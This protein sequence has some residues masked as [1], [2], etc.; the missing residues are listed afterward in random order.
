MKLQK[1]LKDNSSETKPGKSFL[2]DNDGKFST[3]QIHNPTVITIDDDEESTETSHEIQ[4]YLQDGTPVQI[5]PDEEEQDTNIYFPSSKE[6]FGY[7]FNW[8]TNL[9]NLKSLHNEGILK[10]SL[11]RLINCQLKSLCRKFGFGGFSKLNHGQ[12]VDHIY[13]NVIHL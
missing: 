10:A 6:D 9:D 5:I 3:P 1:S 12:L 8:F 11:A 13:K 2:V 4:F 7:N